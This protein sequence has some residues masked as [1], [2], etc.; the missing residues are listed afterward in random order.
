MVCLILI[1]PVEGMKSVCHRDA[2]E[3]VR[4]TSDTSSA[5]LARFVDRLPTSFSSPALSTL[6]LAAF[7]VSAI[8]LS[9]KTASSFCSLLGTHPSSIFLNASLRLI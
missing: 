5:T 2:P 3:M 4:D 7:L 6:L 8:I 1:R 9:L